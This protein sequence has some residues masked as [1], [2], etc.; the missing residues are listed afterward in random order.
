MDEEMNR[1]LLALK[2]AQRNTAMALAKIMGRLDKIDAKLERL[3]KLPTR[4]E[5]NA[6]FEKFSRD[7]RSAWR[8]WKRSAPS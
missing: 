5:M 8:G 1:E 3:D 2:T 4:E 6:R 7:T